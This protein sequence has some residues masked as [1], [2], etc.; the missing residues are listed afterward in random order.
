VQ[1]LGVLLVGNLYGRED[2]EMVERRFDQP[3]DCQKCQPIVQ[4]RVDS[5]LVRRVEDD[6]KGGAAG[7]SLPLAST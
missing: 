2:E 6:R 1:L 7:Q 5:D 4:K 3:R